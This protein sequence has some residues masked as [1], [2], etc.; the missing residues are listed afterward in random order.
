MTHCIACDTSIKR[1]LDISLIDQYMN[2]DDLV[3]LHNRSLKVVTSDV[4]FSESQASLKELLREKLD[5]TGRQ[6]L[7][8]RLIKKQPITYKE[9]KSLIHSINKPETKP[10]EK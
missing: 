10:Q 1:A 3:Y 7:E 8:K 6:S 4:N 2:D 5:K 9:I